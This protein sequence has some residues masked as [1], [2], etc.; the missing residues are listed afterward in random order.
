MQKASGHQPLGL[1]LKTQTFIAY[2]QHVSVGVKT[3]QIGRF[4]KTRQK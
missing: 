1:A 2:K 3:Y 4:E